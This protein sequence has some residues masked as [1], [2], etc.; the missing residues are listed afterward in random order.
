MRE[1][2]KRA[3]T[4][5]GYRVLDASGGDEALEV[6]EQHKGEIDLVV[7]DVIMPGMD[8]PAL[9][10]EIRAT[11]PGMRVIFMSGFTDEFLNDKPED[12]H[13]IGKPFTLKALTE[14]VKD[15]LGTE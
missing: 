11:N 14:K 10:K 3:L 7:T 9:V 4:M 2:A 13:F 15:V 5:R 6:L 12:F 8:G 1:L